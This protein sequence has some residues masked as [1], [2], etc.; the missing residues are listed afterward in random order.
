ME[1][2]SLEKNA[3]MGTVNPKMDAPHAARSKLTMNAN[4]QAENVQDFDVE[5]E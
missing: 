4:G 2:L 1:F 5:M 3:M